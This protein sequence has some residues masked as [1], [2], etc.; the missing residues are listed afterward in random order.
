MKAVK[1]QRYDFCKGQ[2]F[3]TLC[4]SLLLLEKAVSCHSNI[5]REL[6]YNL[7]ITNY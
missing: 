3:S 2:Y 7:I 6:C 5:I 4:V 1:F